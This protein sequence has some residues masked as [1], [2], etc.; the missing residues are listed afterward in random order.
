MKRDGL[1]GSA[2]AKRR[3]ASAYAVEV[4]DCNLDGRS[5]EIAV[6]AAVEPAFERAGAEPSPKITTWVLAPGG[7][8][9]RWILCPGGGVS[10]VVDAAGIETASTNEST[11]GIRLENTIF[12]N[13]VGFRLI[14]R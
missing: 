7:G 4:E 11:M 13:L 2:S 5:P 14:W 9:E 6:I 3:Q 12:R 1:S 8:I 10:S